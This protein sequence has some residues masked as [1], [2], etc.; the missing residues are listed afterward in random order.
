M[1]DPERGAAVT[2]TWAPD[3]PFVLSG[4]S[5]I[6]GATTTDVDE[7]QA[8]ME[9][10][11]ATAAGTDASADEPGGARI[12]RR[13]FLI[14]GGIIAAGAVG[15]VL[16]SSISDS[17]GGGDAENTG[18]GQAGGGVGQGASELNIINWTEYIDLTEGDYL[19]SVDRFQDEAGIA[20]TSGDLTML[21]TSTV[22]LSE[23]SAARA[24][25]RVVD[26]LEDHDDVQNVYA[27]FDIPD[28]I[29]A[30]MTV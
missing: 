9:G 16:L 4:R 6:V 30:T 7:V 3:A 28:D 12:G 26:A 2:L 23:E 1:P 24:V 10:K 22:A 18:G 5:D 29:L 19:G 17:D 11:A 14:G 8:T 20:V 25:L 15:A 21:P 27:N 13:K